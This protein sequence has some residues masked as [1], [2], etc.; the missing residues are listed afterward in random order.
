MLPIIG[1]TTANLPN[2][3]LAIIIVI[4]ALIVII[5]VLFSIGFFAAKLIF[6]ANA[7]VLEGKSITGSLSRSF[8]LTKG[9]FWHVAVASIFAILLYYLFN[10][11][12]VGATV[13]LA[14]VNKAVYIVVNTFAQMS[15]A[16]IEPFILVFITIL[17]VNL[18]VQKEGLDLEVKMR[19]LIAEEKVGM[20]NV[21][22]EKTDA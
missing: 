13:L 5:G 14:F 11:L 19:K 9:K 7:I 12:L 6:G 2:V 18:K 10:S 15:S 20:N 8:Y 4:L 3:V 21:N 17:F 1:L 22:G 16:L